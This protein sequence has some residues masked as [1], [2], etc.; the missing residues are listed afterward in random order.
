MMNTSVS[1]K[2]PLTE[3]LWQWFDRFCWFVS[4]TAL[5]TVL[6]LVVSGVVFRPL[7]WYWRGVDAY[8]A[9]AVGT[10]GF[11]ALAVAWRSNA[12][13]QAKLLVARLPEGWRR[14]WERG[15]LLFAALCATLVAFSAWR[16]VRISWEIGDVSP[17]LDATPLW[18][19]QTALFLGGVAF[20]VAVWHS[21]WRAWRANGN[22][23][24]PLNVT[25][26]PR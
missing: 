23:S 24:A 19:P 20:A 8:A 21:F 14:W 11:F 3:R 17:D 1:Q 26:E 25:E 9:Y 2:A 16:L 10:C 22:G 15:L 12:H 13:I 4:A 18:L 7:G 6:L 5:V